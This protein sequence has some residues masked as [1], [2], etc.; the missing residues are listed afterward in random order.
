MRRKLRLPV[1]ELS[2]NDGKN[3]CLCTVRKDGKLIIVSP[4]EKDRNTIQGMVSVD[5]EIME[6]KF[7]KARIYSGNGNI[8]FIGWFK[9]KPTYSPLLL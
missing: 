3:C 2:S 5:D 7:G 9:Y 6:I 8:N 4:N 1:F